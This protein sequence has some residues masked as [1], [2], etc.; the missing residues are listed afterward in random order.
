MADFPFLDPPDSR[1]ITAGL[2]LLEEIG[3]LEDGAGDPVL[4]PIGRRLARL[5]VDPRLGRMILEAERNDCLREV[6]IIAAGLSI[7]DPRESPADQRAQ[8]ATSTTAA[9][10]IRTPTSSPI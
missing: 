1:Q 5:P 6:T 10:P 9:S 2:A 4:T 7:Q 8:A 3:A